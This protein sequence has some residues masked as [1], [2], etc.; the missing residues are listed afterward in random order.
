MA[1][2]SQEISI[3]SIKSQQILTYTDEKVT[4]N[5]PNADKTSSDI[6]IRK[7]HHNTDNRVPMTKYDTDIE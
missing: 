1:I 2:T 4:N 3:K 7:N 6:K 5:H